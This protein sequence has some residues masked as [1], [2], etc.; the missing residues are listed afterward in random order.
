MQWLSAYEVFRKETAMKTKSSLKHRSSFFSKQEK[1]L[2]CS[3][4]FQT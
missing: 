2:S 4:N 1:I 3:T